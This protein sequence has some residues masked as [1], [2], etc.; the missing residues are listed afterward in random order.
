MLYMIKKAYIMLHVNIGVTWYTCTA[1][2]R[3]SLLTAYCGPDMFLC[4]GDSPTC[5]PASVR[6]D[7]IVDCPEGQDEATD[8]C[9]NS[10]STLC[11]LH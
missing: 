9:H 11:H 2:S 10:M 1:C 8:L 6:C 7:S 5:L 4:D 3:V